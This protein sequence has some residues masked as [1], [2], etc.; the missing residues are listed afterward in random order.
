MTRERADTMVSSF[1]SNSSSS[2]SGSGCSINPIEPYHRLLRPTHN[3]YNREVHNTVRRHSGD[4]AGVIPKAVQR[5]EPVDL[6]RSRSLTA[7]LEKEISPT[8]YSI[9]GPE[10]ISRSHS[11]E[12]S[13]GKAVPNKE[14]ESVYA[15]LARRGTLK[16]EMYFAVYSSSSCWRLRFCCLR[17]IYPKRISWSVFKSCFTKIH[18]CTACS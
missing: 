17:C 16:W 5:V 13:R 7:A 10:P 2:G 12:N 6:L 1:S 4:K 14:E 9:R 3:H 11:F 18:R 15:V 8:K